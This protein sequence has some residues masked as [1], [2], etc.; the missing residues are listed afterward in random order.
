VR[1]RPELLRALAVAGPAKPPSASGSVRLDIFIARKPAVLGAA[2]R[3]AEDANVAAECPSR[4]LVLCS[5]QMAGS[6]WE[7]RG[8]LS[9]QREVSC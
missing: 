2:A 3:Q 4:Q 6:E 9:N 8:L 1:P 5:P 7:G